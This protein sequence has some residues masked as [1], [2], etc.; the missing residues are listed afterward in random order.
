MYQ[1]GKNWNDEGKKLLA[2][3]L[4]YSPQTTSGVTMTLSGISLFD[5][6]PHAHQCNNLGSKNPAC[7]P[8]SYISIDVCMRQHLYF[9]ASC[10]LYIPPLRRKVLCLWILSLGHTQLC[11]PFCL[12]C[13]FRQR[14]CAFFKTLLCLC[15]H[16]RQNN[17]FFREIV[18]YLT[19]FNIKSIFTCG[20]SILRY[21]PANHSRERT[22][23]PL[24]PA[25]PDQDRWC[26]SPTV[27]PI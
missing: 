18:Y 12:Q 11:F 14:L 9:R 1:N 7:I 27:S 26:T 16:S 2:F 10:A 13:T 25:S 17:F 6:Y 23:I 8:R 4:T 15:L 21:N 20:H 5:R 3:R 22:C 24:K 19:T